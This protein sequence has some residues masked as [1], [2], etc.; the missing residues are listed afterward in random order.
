MNAEEVARRFEFARPGFSLV[1]Y[2]EIALPVYRLRVRALLMER[3]KLDTIQEFLMRALRSGVT[4]TA[5]MEAFY[6][7]PNSVVR[8][9]FSEMVRAENVHIGA[10]A[11]SI[12][13]EWALTPKGDLT[14]D[15]AET[16]MPEEGVFEFDYDGLLRSAGPVDRYLASPRQTRD[17][18]MVEVPAIPN[19]APELEELSFSDVAQAMRATFS[20]GRKRDLLSIA[21]IEKRSRFFRRGVALVYR[22]AVAETVQVAIAVNDVLSEE[23]EKAFAASK[24][25]SKL[26]MDAAPVEVR[27]EGELGVPVSAAQ[28]SERMR[29]ET[30]AAD[31][32]VHAARQNVNRAETQQARQKAER[33][34]QKAEAAAEDVGRRQAEAEVRFLKVFEHPPLLAQA[35]VESTERLLIIS[36]WLNPVVVNRE[37]LERLDRLL[38]KGVTVYI[39]YGIAQENERR[40]KG[41]DASAEVA[42]QKLANRHQ[43]LVLRRLGDTHAKVLAWDRACVCVSSFNWLSFKGDRLRGYRDEQGVAVTTPAKVDQKFAEVLPRFQ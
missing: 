11:G 7:L 34:L 42:L 10:A 22:G 8:S 43:Q 33:E 41:A 4:R 32:S 36:P 17:D 27:L 1:G 29:R 40:N 21:S 3:R 19:R 28:E 9:T 31:A 24:L 23:Y 30:S 13:H 26:G 37:F 12:A 38:G 18:G 39:G 16:T 6:G 35:L 25:A 14:L 2:E 15:A 20:S 5:D